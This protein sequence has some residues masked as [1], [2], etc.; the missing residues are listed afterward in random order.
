[1]LNAY[2][3]IAHATVYTKNIQLGVDHLVNIV[4]NATVKYVSIQEKNK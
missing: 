2:I 1:M 3:A 4:G